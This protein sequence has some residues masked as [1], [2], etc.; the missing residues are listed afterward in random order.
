M[1]LDAEGKVRW[2]IDGLNFPV[3]AQVLRHDRVLIVEY[4]GGVVSERTFKGEVK[5]QVKLG[6]STWPLGAQRLRNGHT[7][8]YTRSA[9]LE[10]DRAGKKVLTLARHDVV[11]AQVESDG[12]ICLLSRSGKVIR[13]D[14]S[15]KELSSFN[16]GRVAPSK[17][18]GLSLQVLPRGHVL[19]PLYYDSKVAEYDKGGKEVW[20]VKMLRPLSAR[21]LRNGDIL[22]STP[23]RGIVLLDKHGKEKWRKMMD[24]IVYFADAR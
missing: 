21:R 14:R 7:F 17:R 12:S 20:S 2:E 9:L 24:G 4:R 10:Y 16:V 8:V 3:F 6:I 18:I 13:L 19:L 15:G 5:W 23:A 22:V 1:E 11:S